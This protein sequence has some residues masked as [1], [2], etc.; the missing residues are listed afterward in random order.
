MSVAF[1]V[2]PDVPTVFVGG[3]FTGVIDPETKMVRPQHRERYLRLLSF[4]EEHGWATLS[5]H[6]AEGWGTAILPAN[7]CTPRDLEWMRACDLFVAFPG[8][9]V[10]PGTHIEIGWASALNKPMVL[11]LE[12]ECRHADLVTGLATVAPVTYVTYSDRP[13]LLD[14][15]ATAADTVAAQV[16]ASWRVG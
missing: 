15:L 10:S 14:E 2:L 8:D 6:R 12:P 5:A 16:G 7:S 9:P 13:E 4:F 3:P 11:L 1:D